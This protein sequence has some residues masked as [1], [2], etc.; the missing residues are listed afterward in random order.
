[1]RHPLIMGNW[2]L[3]GNTHMVNE[4]VTKLRRQLINVNGCN[5]AISPPVMYLDQ[6]RKILT[7][8]NIAL[9]AQNVDINSYG[10]FTG[11]ISANMLKDIGTK[12]IIIGHFERRIY[13]KEKDEIIAKKFAIV[14]KTGLIPILCI[15]ETQ[16]ES[17]AG[18]AEEVYSRQ[19]DAI[20]KTSGVEAMQ[21]AVIA[22]EPV[23]A[24]GTGQCASPTQ[25]QAAH[26]F[27]RNHI[28]KQDETIANKVIIQ[29]GGS[30]NDKNAAQ[31]FTQPDIDGALVGGASLQAD[32]FTT[33]VKIAAAVKKF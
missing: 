16:I 20:L 30:V 18:K 1:M 27:I 3:H 12:Y 31:L 15:G 23:W 21:D 24:I 4:L 13:H 9:G 32:T 2:K 25:A 17:E 26:K 11:E 33:I 19:I 8:T 7:N 28:A 10:A 29:Y 14:K 6:A 22:Y 5:I